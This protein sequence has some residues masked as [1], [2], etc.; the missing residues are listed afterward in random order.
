[1]GPSDIPRRLPGDE[2]IAIVGDL[3]ETDAFNCRPNGRQLVLIFM[4]PQKPTDP[5]TNSLKDA[6]LRLLVIIDD[7]P[8]VSLPA[9]L[10][11]TDDREH[12]RF[13][14]TDPLV[15]ELMHKARTATK[16]VA[17]AAE[18]D[19]RIIESISFDTQELKV[20]D[21]RRDERLRSQSSDTS[22]WCSEAA[23]GY[24]AQQFP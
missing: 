4:M 9:S 7:E 10:Y 15:L 17:L 18:A 5:I 23:D 14:S 22:W 11:T 1:M 12:Y 24:S 13:W 8:K 19:G 21:H 16:R 20:G 3:T 6:K 2:H